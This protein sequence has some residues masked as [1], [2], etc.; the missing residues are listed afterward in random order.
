M[1]RWPWPDG[2][3]DASQHSTPRDA[4][5]VADEALDK[6]ERLLEEM[7]SMGLGDDIEPS[8]HQQPLS[9]KA[10]VSSSTSVG[11]PRLV[12]PVAER[13][14]E[15]QAELQQHHSNEQTFVD[16][17]ELSSLQPQ[18]EQ[19]AECM[20]VSGIETLFNDIQ[21]MSD[22][23]EEIVNDYMSSNSDGTAA[24]PP[25]LPEIARCDRRVVKKVVR[26]A[27]AIGNQRDAMAFL[28]NQSPRHLGACAGGQMQ[29]PL[30][31]QAWSSSPRGKLVL[32]SV[33]VTQFHYLEVGM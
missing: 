5:Q 29:Q 15:C 4:E 28:S 17:T 18:Q 21:Q 13:Q 10:S 25:K 2:G 22:R 11:S 8:W 20:V 16:L 6:I 27:L 9:P 7:R 19:Q 31:F 12:S 3:G 32:K 33:T 30:G 1:P 23:M 24:A 26:P 14:A